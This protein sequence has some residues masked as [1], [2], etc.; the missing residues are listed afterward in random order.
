MF[1]MPKEKINNSKLICVTGF[2]GSG[3]STFVNFLKQMGCE[4]FVADEFVHNSYLKGNIGFKI[5]KDNFGIDYVND[6]CVDRPKL[7]ELILNNQEK[8]F[9]LEKLMNKVIYD[10]IFELKKENRQIIVELGTYLFFEEYFKDLFH[11]VVVV[12]SLDKNYKKNNFKKFS[13]IEKFSTKPVG[14]SQNPQKEG[15]FYTDFL[16]GNHGNLLDLEK[17]AKDFLKV[18]THI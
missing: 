9:L 12:D 17:K 14:N 6:E 7:R 8:K 4:T 18:L 1:K 15:V 5:I 16:V 2:M 10:K 3:K 13:K 11:K